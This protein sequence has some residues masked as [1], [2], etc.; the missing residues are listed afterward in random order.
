MICGIYAGPI[1]EPL[2]YGF[3]IAGHK[4]SIK[5]LP[6]LLYVI[7]AKEQ[8]KGTIDNLRCDYPMKKMREKWID[9]AKGI[10]ILLVI[11]GHASG[12]LTGIWDFNFV[13]GIHLVIFFVLSGYTLREEKI[14]RHYVN[15]KF[16]RLMVPYF[17]TCAA[18]MAMDVFNSCVRDSRNSIG[19]VTGIIAKDLARSFMASGV[20]TKFGQ[21]EIGRRI[22]AVWF[23]PAMF[24]GLLFVQL[25]F[26]CVKDRRTRGIVAAIIA[27]FGYISAKFIWLPFSIQSGMMAVFFVWLGYEIRQEDLLARVKW[28]HYVYAQI[29]L[30]AGIYFG[31]CGI[32]YARGDIN[33]LILSPVVGMAGCLLVYGIARIIHGNILPKIGQSTMTILCVHLFALETMRSYFDSVIRKIGEVEGNSYVW[34]YI[35]LHIAFAV[36]GGLL[37]EWVKKIFHQLFGDGD[38]KSVKTEESQ[39]FILEVT[40][41]IFV[42]SILVGCFTVD[43][44]FRQIIYSCQM[45]SVIF[46]FGYT[47]NRQMTIKETVKKTATEFLLPYFIFV[48]FEFCLYIR[49][50]RLSDMAIMFK[51][52]ALGMSFSKKIMPNTPSVGLVYFILVLFGVSLVYMC[53]DKY[54]KDEGRQWCAVL[55]ISVIGTII[56]KRGYWLPWSFDIACYAVVF[57]KLGLY[58]KEH[59]ILEKIQNNFSWYFILS[60]FWVYMIYAG[61]MELAVREYGQYGLVVIG[62]VAGIFII[63]LFSGYLTH[64]LHPLACLLALTGKS[65]IVM[66]ILHILLGEKINRVL[67]QRIIY[68]ENIA[69]LVVSVIIQMALA[70]LVS[71]MLSFVRSW[72]KQA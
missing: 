10:A 58:C 15:K 28:W 42:L 24:F 44:A 33:D 6:C 50:V 49:T 52:Y 17:W 66:W 9:N 60:P 67:S 31:Y 25:L 26:Q 51:K 11:L 45:V 46:I 61:S 62:A 57:F 39:D 3:M 68:E 34:R 22:G 43:G 36:L 2:T 47:Y 20:W 48:I 13:Y 56:G 12:N 29:I 32:G 71:C 72:R 21:V 19:V 14:T 5:C 37:I 8:K 69:F 23:L 16:S 30:L 7:N 1:R 65:A 40:K 35:L 38:H 27:T 64:A 53:I 63:Y 55:L 4:T 41:G 18:V 70:I 59:H 54:I